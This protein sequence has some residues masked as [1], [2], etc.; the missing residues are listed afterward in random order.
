M[1]KRRIIR[2]E[3]EE[4]E[5][6]EDKKRPAFKP[7]EF[8]ETEFLQTENRSAKLIYIS[9]ATALV[10]GIVTFGFMTLLHSMGVGG[11]FTIPLIIPV[12]FAFVAVYMFTR[13]GIDVKNLE[14]KKWLE[15]GFMYVVAWFAVWLLSMNPPFSDFADPTIAEPLIEVMVA[16]DHVYHYLGDDMYL[17]D[18]KTDFISITDI[19]DIEEIRIYS[20]ITDNWKLDEKSVI[21]QRQNSDGSWVNM[22]EGGS[23]NI[24]IGRY[25][26]DFDQDKN[27]SNKL[28]ERWLISEDDVRSDHMYIVSLSVANGSLSSTSEFENFRVVYSARDGKGNE[29]RLEVP[30]RL[31]L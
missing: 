4:E 23:M 30:I 8:D 16:D 9:L 17:D 3:S 13:F 24:T 11:L 26:G 12:I 31:K 19:E 27:V 6:E 25:D 5:P 14:W 22:E 1:A 28:D 15:N 18:K 20:T 10:A 29:A 2:E 21:F 7:P